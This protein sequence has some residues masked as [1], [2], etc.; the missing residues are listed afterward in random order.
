MSCQRYA[1][2]IVDHACGADLAADAAAHL[3][4]CAACAALFAE[5]RRAIGDLDRELQ[6][7]LAIEPSVQF[8]PRVRA[9][10]ESAPA[11]ARRGAMLW[12]TGLAAAAVVVAV[13]GSLMLS[14]PER[15]TQPAVTGNGS[16]APAIVR[17]SESAPPA[18]P[19]NP[20][21]ILDPL[22][23]TRPRPVARIARQRAQPPEPEII[24]SSAQRVAI[25]RYVAMFRAGSLETSALAAPAKPVLP[26]PSDLV[27]APLEVEPITAPGGD[28]S[29]TGAV[30]RRHD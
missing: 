19:V 15:R 23:D 28:A 20:A 27:V 16:P 17:G 22:P 10:V 13:A 3:Q 1:G 8:A 5:Q 24:V 4:G 21:R 29:T 2:A 9:A 6:A 12:W 18:A 26:P 11:Q 7:A 25:D 30:E 14:S